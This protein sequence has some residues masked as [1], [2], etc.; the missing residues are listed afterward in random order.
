MADNL[1]ESD[2]YSWMLQQSELLKEEKFSDADMENIIKEISGMASNLEHELESRLK[3]LFVY[4]LKWQ[5]Q[6]GYRA[7]FS[8]KNIIDRCIINRNLITKFPS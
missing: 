5:Y 2:F 8:H 4:L 1:Y 3:A 6:A 7:R